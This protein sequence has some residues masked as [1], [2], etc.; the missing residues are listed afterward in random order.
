MVA[1]ALVGTIG[2]ERRGTDCIGKARVFNFQK[3]GQL[4]KVSRTTVPDC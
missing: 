3:Y 4:L 1:F 2:K